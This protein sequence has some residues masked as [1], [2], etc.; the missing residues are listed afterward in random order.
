MERTNKA[1]A[2]YG[3]DNRKPLP[4]RS[5]PQCKLGHR[6]DPLTTSMVPSLGIES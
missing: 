6:L 1:Q 2:D 3:T 5:L 4:R